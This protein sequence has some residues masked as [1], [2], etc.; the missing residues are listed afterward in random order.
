MYIHSRY[1]RRAN[2]LCSFLNVSNPSKLRK[3]HVCLFIKLMKVFEFLQKVSCEIVCSK[4]KSLSSIY[5]VRAV[6][7]KIPL[8]YPAQHLK[9]VTL[10]QGWLSGRQRQNV[11]LA[12]H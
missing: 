12:F 3:L 11:G 6:K 9:C 10:H 8:S 1:F 2:A 7:L 5:L 4:S